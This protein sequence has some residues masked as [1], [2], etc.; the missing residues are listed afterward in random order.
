MLIDKTDFLVEYFLCH[1]MEVI[2]MIV[3]FSWRKSKS[4]FVLLCLIFRFLCRFK[5][6]SPDATNGS[7]S[8]PLHE[9][10]K[11]LSQRENKRKM[12]TQKS[13]HLFLV[14]FSDIF[15]SA[16]SC[17]STAEYKWT[18]R[19]MNESWSNDRKN[20]CFFFRFIFIHFYLSQEVSVSSVFWRNLRMVSYRRRKSTAAKTKRHP[21]RNR[22]K[23]NERKSLRYLRCFRYVWKRK[24]EEKP[25]SREKTFD[26]SFDFFFLLERTKSKNIVKSR[27]RAF[28]QFHCCA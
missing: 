16:H 14:F 9:F 8:I 19:T 18:N 3:V 22:W 25:K 6:F 28:T 5:W 23:M 26:F 10:I 17:L 24:H 7:S 27:K 2:E 20:K 1:S 15:L 4:K 11:Y 12:S 21:W 13:L